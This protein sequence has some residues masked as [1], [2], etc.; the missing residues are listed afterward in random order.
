ML[1]TAQKYNLKKRN[2]N[3]SDLS[4]E[5]AQ[6]LS[7]IKMLLM[8]HEGRVMTMVDEKINGIKLPDLESVLQTI[9]GNDG[10]D[11][12]AEDIAECLMMMPEFIAL[13]RANDGKTPSLEELRALIIPLIPPPVP[14]KDGKDG[15]TPSVDVDEIIRIVVSLIPPPKNGEDGT[16]GSPDKPIEIADKLNTLEEKVEMR[17][18][19]GL[20]L[21]L[22]N[23]Q[24]AIREKGGGRQIAGSGATTGGLT[25]LEATGTVDGLTNP[26]PNRVFTFT[27]APVIIYI[28]SVPYQKVQSDGTV[29]WTGTTTVTLI[30]APNYDVFGL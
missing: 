8:E 14:G 13:T 11:A 23:L 15:V 5:R 28:D 3:F 29:I 6:I 30:K 7:E 21:A 2:P 1:T 10:E 18:I 26:T 25:K 19:K 4:T 16:N 17:V 27:T 9:K 20:A 22:K 24:R 12:D